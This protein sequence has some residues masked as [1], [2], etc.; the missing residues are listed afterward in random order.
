MECMCL[1]LQ[2]SLGPDSYWEWNRTKVN[3]QLQN[4]SA[5]NPLASDAHESLRNL[6]DKLF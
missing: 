4:V 1:P 3:D 5:A 6:A 2:Y